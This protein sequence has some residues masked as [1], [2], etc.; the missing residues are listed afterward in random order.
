MSIVVWSVVAGRWVNCGRSWRASSVSYM[1]IVTNQRLSSTR[2]EIPIANSKGPPTLCLQ[3][4]GA[5]CLQQQPT[6][7]Q[8]TR[9][10][11][12]H[13]AR[14]WESRKLS[15]DIDLTRE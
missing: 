4:R 1:G 14:D 6:F 5:D 9:T 7:L 12:D 15:T 13:M 3:N 10:R 8:L 2:S 11:D